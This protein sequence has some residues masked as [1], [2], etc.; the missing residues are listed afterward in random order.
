MPGA[1]ELIIIFF[2]VLVLFGA[3]KV[4]K[5]ARDIGTGIKEFKKSL[6]DK[7]EDKKS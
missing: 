7:D 6:S 4:P 5:I 1:G 3:G 2:I